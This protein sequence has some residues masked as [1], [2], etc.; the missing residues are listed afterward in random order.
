VWFFMLM[1]E[2]VSDEPVLRL[3]IDMAQNGFSCAS[4]RSNN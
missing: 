3:F 4:T 1:A 2:V